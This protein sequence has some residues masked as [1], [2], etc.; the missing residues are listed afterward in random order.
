MTLRDEYA[1]LKRPQKEMLHVYE[2]RWR[3]GGKTLEEMRV[4]YTQEGMHRDVPGKLD[5]SQMVRTL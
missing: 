1:L 5:W 3:R 2:T 4:L